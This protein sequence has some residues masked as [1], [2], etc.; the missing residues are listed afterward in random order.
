MDHGGDDA[1]GVAGAAAPDVIVV[2]ARCEERRHGVDVRGEG[3]GRLAP[4]G[5]DVEPL[6][7]DGHL[8]DGAAVFGRERLQAFE[9]EI[10]RRASSLSVMDSM[11]TSARVS[12]NTFITLLSRSDA[13]GDEEGR[14]REA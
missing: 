4:V 14:T 3:D 6:L 7:G 9:R 12:S 13:D 8:L 11:S 5:E 1:L 2:F 10:R